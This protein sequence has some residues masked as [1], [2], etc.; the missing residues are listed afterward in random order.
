MI[1]CCIDC[2]HWQGERGENFTAACAARDDGRK[3]IG[4]TERDCERFE[5]EH[6]DI[7]GHCMIEDDSDF[8]HHELMNWAKWCWEGEDPRPLPPQVCGSAEGSYVPTASEDCLDKPENKPKAV[9]HRA[10][11][12]QGLFERMP[13]KLRAVMIATYPRAHDSKA[14]KGEKYVARFCKMRVAEYKLN[15]AEVYRHVVVAFRAAA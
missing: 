12:V 10:E 2:G 15:L 6:L 3:Y 9:A 4:E 11:V 5:P 8:A 13:D 1:V 14:F 7:W